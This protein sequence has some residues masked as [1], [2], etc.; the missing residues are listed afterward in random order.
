MT[1]SWTFAVFLILQSF[2]FIESTKKNLTFFAIS[3]VGTDTSGRSV[4]GAQWLA[5]QEINNNTDLLS[6]YEL[7]LEV[8][9]AAGDASFSLIQALDIANDHV[10][11]E[12]NIYFPIVLGAPWSSISTSTNPVLGAFNM[13]QISGG[14]TS[15]ALSDTSKYPYFYR[16]LGISL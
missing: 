1:M 10:S 15:I 14:A 3:N 6:N 7:K 11:T 4:V 5:I 8:Y 9:D 16:Y 2:H 13:G 12:N